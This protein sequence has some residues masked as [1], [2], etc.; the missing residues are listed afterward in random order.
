MQQ[1]DHSKIKSSPRVNRGPV[2]EQ[3]LITIC[4]VDW[5]IFSSV[6]TV[7]MADMEECQGFPEPL[8]L[9]SFHWGTTGRVSFMMLGKSIIWQWCH[10]QTHWLL[11]TEERTTLGPQ[12]REAKS[13]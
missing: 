6:L 1:E 3:C 2:L 11:A 8:C 4:I 5:N 7:P 9:F 13:A 12:R 10:S